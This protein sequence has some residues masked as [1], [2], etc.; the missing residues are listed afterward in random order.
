MSGGGSAGGDYYAVIF[1]SRLSGAGAG[2]ATAT[3]PDYED[4]ARRMALL[5]QEEAGFLGMESARDPV[6]GEGITV[7]YWRCLEDIARWRDHSVHAEARRLGRLHFYDSFRIR[8]SKVFD[9]RRWARP[10]DPAAGS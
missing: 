6:T 10:E 7:S 8:I 9:D 3:A 1:S 2:Q 5:A 4:W